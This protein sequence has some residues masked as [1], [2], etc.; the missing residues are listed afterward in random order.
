MLAGAGP[1]RDVMAGLAKLKQTGMIDES[2]IALSGWS[3]GGYMTVWLAGHYSGWKAAV[4]G[5]AVTDWV[6]QYN[7]SDANASRGPA[8][9]GSPWIG[10]NMQKYI[11][12]SPIT[13]ARNIKAPTL[14][15]ANTGDPRV[16]ITQS[17][18]LFHTLK[19]NGVETKF[20]AWPIPAHNASD[21]V[22]QMDRDR[23]WISWLNKYLGQ[24]N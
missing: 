22:S 3:Y 6:D 4:A 17:Y 8:L 10:K 20:Y 13:E 1:G 2:K 19:D 23:L 18:K 24:A 9:G 21:P 7:V 12:Q 15:L 11:D 5:A 16:P 14:I